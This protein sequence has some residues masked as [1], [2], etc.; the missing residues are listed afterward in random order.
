MRIDSRDGTIGIFSRSQAFL[1]S[2]SCA[3]GLRRRQ[4]NAVGFVVQAG[5]GRV[6]GAEDA[7][8]RVELVVVRL[9][10]VVRDRPVVAEA[11][12]AS[13]RRKSSGPK[14]SEMRPQ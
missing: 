7:D 3:R 11:V 5:L 8:E 9:H 10:L 4:E 1:I 12:D 14:R 2:S 6:V 13:C